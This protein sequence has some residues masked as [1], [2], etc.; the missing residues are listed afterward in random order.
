MP[1]ETGKTATQI[2]IESLSGPSVPDTDKR[3]HSS[4][5]LRRGGALVASFFLG[6]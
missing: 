3:L 5:P 1:D 2:R 4:V 6:A